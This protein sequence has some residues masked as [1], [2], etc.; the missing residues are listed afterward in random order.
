MSSSHSGPRPLL[1][2][3]T[4]EN[5]PASL[6]AAHGYGGVVLEVNAATLAD[7]EAM[8]RWA[9]E[10]RA[11]SLEFHLD[12]SRF[13]CQ[14]R[15]DLQ[16]R[17]LRF[18]EGR[19]EIKESSSGRLDPFNP[20][21]TR[22]L[23]AWLESFG[24]SLMTGVLAEVPW[25]AV[26][27]LASSLSPFPW[28]PLLAGQFDE[29]HLAALVSNTGDH[30]ARLR[31]EYWQTLDALLAANFQTPLDRWCVEKQI[32][33]FFR[34][35]HPEWEALHLNRVLRTRLDVALASKVNQVFWPTLLNGDAPDALLRD[36]YALAAAG[37]SRFQIARASSAY[38]DEAKLLN[39]ALVRAAEKAPAT[40]NAARVGVLFPERSCQ[41][42]YHP[43]GHRLTRWVGEDLQRTCA[44]LDDLHFDWFFV[45]E[46]DDWQQAELIVVTNLT[47]S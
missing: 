35:F 11:A 7:I 45:R 41:A 24:S 4:V 47:K 43:N 17:Y 39:A 21:S 5:S 44:L 15:T 29:A 23:I 33:F 16:R 20:E 46:K 19:M 34:C 13:P 8:R 10:I 36:G 32:T 25:R 27:E 40:T 31:Q 2:L 37:A 38:G 18:A 42:H 22:F 14:Q 28:S 12:I 1:R 6:I 3:I 26:D 30:A 9:N